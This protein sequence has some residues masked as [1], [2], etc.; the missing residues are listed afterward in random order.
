MNMIDKF[1]I[2]PI[3]VLFLLMALVSSF[4]FAGCSGKDI[5]ENNPQAVFD[6]A[7]DD[8]KDKRY[9]MALDKM[10]NLKNK[11]PYSHLATTAQ[12]RIADIHFLEEAFIESAGAYET[13]RDLHPKYEKADYVIFR[14]GESYFNQLPSSLDRDLTPAAK[15]IDAYRELGTLYPKSEYLSTARQHLAEASEQLS[16]KER[17][18]ADFYFKREMYDS[19]ARRYEKI[20]SKYPETKTDQYSYL[21]W[22]QSLMRQSE[23]P[24]FT[25]KKVALMSEA[26]HVFRTYLARYPSGD[27]AKEISSLLE[28]RFKD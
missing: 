9:Q 21:R 28:N 7:E 12:L 15:A 16:G 11:F 25:E 17:Y 2:S 20:A 14:I 19:A 24:E 6:D 26:K 8:V 22:G 27:Y 23:Q 18:I 13:F 5:D 1:R 3:T 10:K 4:H